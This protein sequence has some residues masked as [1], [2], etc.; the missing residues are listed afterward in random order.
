MAR[1]AVSRSQ[2]P[3]APA[4]TCRIWSE[5][6]RIDRSGR[7]TAPKAGQSVSSPCRDAAAVSK[8]LVNPIRPCGQASWQR[9][10]KKHSPVSITG[11]V[12]RMAPARQTFRHSRQPAGHSPGTISGRPR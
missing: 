7:F 5:R 12:R 10:Q 2:T 4:S 8:R 3:Q 6:A 1:E 9:P 11:G